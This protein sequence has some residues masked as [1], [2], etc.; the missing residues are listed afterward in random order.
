MMPTSCKSM[1][2]KI[3][4]KEMINLVIR[5]FKKVKSNFSNFQFKKTSFSRFWVLSCFSKNSMLKGR[6]INNNIFQN[7]KDFYFDEKN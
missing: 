2:K 5:K 6:V 7:S 1:H 3:V 4:I